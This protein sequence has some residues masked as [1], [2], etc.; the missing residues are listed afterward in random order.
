MTSFSG[1]DAL[2]DVRSA[3]MTKTSNRNTLSDFASVCYLA[4]SH[5]KYYFISFLILA[6]PFLQITQMIQYLNIILIQWTFIFYCCWM[7]YP[8]NWFIQKANP[9]TANRLY[10]HIPTTT[11]SPSELV[12]WIQIDFLL[13]CSQYS[14]TI[15]IQ[16]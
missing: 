1:G 7:K 6:Q 13:S 4:H 8:T 14:L 9:Y 16:H 11:N 2:Y 10:S 15:R 12:L 3:E 5:L